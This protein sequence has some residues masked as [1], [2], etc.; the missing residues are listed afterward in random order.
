MTTAALPKW[1]PDFKR[2][3]NFSM[4]I[5]ASRG[6]G[7]SYLT[8]YLLTYH[9]RDKFDLFV[10][11]SESEDE[12]EK[13]REILPGKLFFDDFNPDLIQNL[14]RIN[15]DRQRK[16]QPIYETLIVFDDKISNKLKYSDELLQLFTRGRHVGISIIFISQSHSYANAA[17]RNNSDTIIMLKQNSRQARVAIT[18]NVMMGALDVPEGANE[19]QFYTDVM[20][21]YM[22][23]EGDAVVLDYRKG[24]FDNL[25][26]YRAPEITK[27]PTRERSPKAAPAT[28]PKPVEIEKVSEIVLESGMGTKVPFAPGTETKVPEK[29]TSL[30]APEETSAVS[31]SEKGTSLLAPEEEEESS[32]SLDLCLF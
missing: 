16:S 19:K 13:Y 29:G 10:V 5:L 21:K 4:L 15:K 7:K 27:K 11:I 22:N 25:Y 20:R 31:I 8:Q 30:L 32:S 6:S 23:S 9:L 1:K 28:P 14:I 12:L 2:G 24:A 26:Q 18:E 3:K 17:W